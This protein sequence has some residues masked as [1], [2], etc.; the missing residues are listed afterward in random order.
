MHHRQTGP[1]QTS[2]T[3][4]QERDAIIARELAWLTAAARAAV[5]GTPLPERPTGRA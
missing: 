3:T 2:P 5:A 1:D 4:Q